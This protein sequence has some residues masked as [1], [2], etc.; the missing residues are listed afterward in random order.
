MADFLRAVEFTLAQEGVYSNDRNDSGG[1]TKFGISTP[2]FREYQRRTGLLRDVS[3]AALTRD[4][5]R[6][7]YR[8]LF[9]RFDSLESQMIATKVFDLCVNMGPSTGVLLAQQAARML[10]ATIE[11]D[12]VFGPRTSA[13]IN[14]LS[15]GRRLAF[16][17]A[18]VYQAASRYVAI[19]AKNPTQLDFIDGWLARLA[20]RPQD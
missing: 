2:T 8:A 20:R 19:V 10:G 17:K 9:W 3:V 11:A 6:E 16:Y 5:A 12:G 14:G 13:A 1:V 15:R 4:E 18:L 7:V